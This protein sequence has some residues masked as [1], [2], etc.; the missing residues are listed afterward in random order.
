MR[1]CQLCPGSNSRLMISSTPTITHDV[2]VPADYAIAA[3][4]DLQGAGCVFFRLLRVLAAVEF[5]RHCERQRSNLGP[6]RS[7]GRDC[8]S[9][10]AP[11]ND[12]VNLVE[13]ARTGGQ[14]AA[15]RAAGF[16]RSGE[17]GAG[18]FG[19]RRVEVSVNQPRIGASADGGP[20]LRPVLLAAQAGEA[21][22]TAQFCDFAFCRRATSMAV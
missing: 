16:S 18:V 13:I 19:G 15:S 4:R 21:H 14:P 2:I 5:N 7:I 1:E 20:P 6:R 11:R 12:S 17:E 3:T 22:G 8:L 10:N 9:A